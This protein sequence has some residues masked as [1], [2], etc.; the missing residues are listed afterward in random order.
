MGNK[1]NALLWSITK[2]EEDFSYI[3]GTMHIF[4]AKL[5][6]WEEQLHQ[7]IS[8]CDT[9]YTE[10][11]F[12][13]S[14]ISDIQ[15]NME[16]KSGVTLKNLFKPKLYNYLKKVFYKS[17]GLNLENMID[18]QPIVIT[19]LIQSSFVTKE[20]P[21]S[22]DQSLWNFA[23]YSGKKVDG[24]EMYEDQLN[25]MQSF[26]IGYQVKQLKSL[27]KNFKRS[28]MQMKKMVELYL[29]QDIRGLYLK[30]LKGL[31]QY[32]KILVQYRNKKMLT[33]ILMQSE[34]ECSFYAIGAAHLYG[35]SGL[36]AGLKRAGWKVKPVKLV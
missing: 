34:Q 23:K 2:N 25:I 10:V 14:Q 13:D 33:S 8:E 22:I 32:K 27:L 4:D 28:R 31:K 5:F 15:D 16:L 29:N 19:N 35:K 1:K 7:I 26:E 24:L 21:L 20:M 9:F 12:N 11:D 6:R 36:I 17:T 18:I 30:S 3:F